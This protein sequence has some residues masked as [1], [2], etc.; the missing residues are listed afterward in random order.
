MFYEVFTAERFFAEIQ[1]EEDAIA[2]LWKCKFGGKEFCCPSCKNENFYKIETRLE[3]RTCK[4]CL[5]QNRLR[6]GTIFKASKTKLLVWVKA[7]FY[8]MQ[9]KRGVSAVELQRH[10]GQKSYGRVWTMLQKIRSALQQKDEEYKV[11]DGVV[12]VDG[13]TFGRREAGNQCEVLIAIESK[14]WVDSKGKTKSKAGFAKILVAKE[15]KENAQKLIDQSVKAGSMVNTDGSPSLTNLEKV[16]VDYQV[17]SGDKEACD[18]WLPWV[19]RFISNAKTWVNGT[20]H[21]VRA[22][23]LSRYLGEYTYRFNRRHDVDRLFHRALTA[24]AVA[25]PIQVCALS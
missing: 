24:C 4:K 14:E 16:D 8:M 25:Q 5:K 6:S 15:T 9:G 17:V 19:H 13:A 21:G 20:H 18:R 2:L 3:V 10:L 23:H 11:G 12:E 1:T 7:I 22:K